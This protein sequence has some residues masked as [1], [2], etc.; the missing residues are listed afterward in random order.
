MFL[1]PNAG[2]KLSEL[3]VGV[4]G[5]LTL[6]VWGRDVAYCL[7]VLS[8]TPI[9]QWSSKDTLVSMA[10]KA[11]MFNVHGARQPPGAG[12][13]KGWPPLIP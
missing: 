8:V 6:G 5:T 7:V 9:S 3:G 4:T 13:S 12:L 1:G 2:F 10:R 11:S